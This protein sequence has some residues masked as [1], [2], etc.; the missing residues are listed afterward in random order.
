MKFLNHTPYPAMLFR[1]VIED[2][3]NAAAAIMRITYD[4]NLDGLSIASEQPW[5]LS[6][7]P[8]DGP[9]GPMD[10][11]DVF[12]RGGIDVFLWGEACAPRG[13]VVQQMTVTLEIGE[14]FRRDV[15]V[16][17]D[18]VWLRQG[19]TLVPSRPAPFSRM[20]LG[21]ENAF[22][23]KDTWDGLEVPYQDNPSGKGF[24][25][26]EA[27]VPGTPLPNLEEPD[28]RIVH[29]D[30]R[31]APAL[32]GPCLM[33]SGLRLHN[34]IRL[35]E[36]GNLKAFRPHFFNAAH[37]RMIAEKIEPGALVRLTGVS[38]DGPVTFHLPDTRPRITLRFDDQVHEVA[39]FIDQV[40]I[41]LLDQHV[42]VTWRYPFRY[43][44]YPMQKRVCE[45]RLNS[46]S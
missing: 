10:G 29:W 38:P 41:D 16:V 17:G 30:D 20:S 12:Y 2:D 18:R 31:P 26:E 25:M 45:V 7:A 22:G 34:A 37:P 11:D 35:D 5:I 13:R 28:A 24:R 27:N 21:A 42:F 8:W 6:S 46:G 14:T 9:R 15:A 33:T 19:G 23:G 40:G 3:R 4:L 44:I 1:T 43:T 36:A 39:P 32:L